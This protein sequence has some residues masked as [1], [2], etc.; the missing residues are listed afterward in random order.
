MRFFLKPFTGEGNPAG[1]TFDGSIA[2]RADTLSIRY[3][4]R[5]NLSKVSIPAAAEA[6]RRKDRLWEGTCL[7]LFLGTADSG[8]YWEFNLSPSGHWNVY[9]FTRYREGMRE[10]PAITSLPF[11]VRRDS[12][13]LL[14]TAEFGIGTI[15]PAGKDL[16]IGVAAVI[17]T[18]DGGK[19]HWAL[20][21][22]ASLP[23]F[24]RRDG[25]ALILP[26]EG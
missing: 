18:I 17:G 23:D 4:V 9:R 12:E 8:E 5:G 11:D 15:V 24:H 6:P 13:A 10:E 21:H 16:A 14:L 25:F 7:E 19:N 20:V 26:G 2:R 22:P 1:V 3:E